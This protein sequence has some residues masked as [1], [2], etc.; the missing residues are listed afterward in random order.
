MSNFRQPALIWGILVAAVGF[1][2][3]PDYLTYSS[4]PVEL[5]EDANA[6]IRKDEVTVHIESYDQVTVERDRIV[7][8]RNESGMGDV[9]AHQFFDD[10]TSIR[11][12]NVIVYDSDGNEL[13]EI[14][15]RDFVEESAVSNGTL[16]SDSRVKFLRYIPRQ[17]PITFHFTSKVK[18]KSTAFLPSWTP[19]N[20]YYAST[21]SSHFKVINDADEVIKVKE[22]NLEDYNIEKLG[23]LSYSAT[24]IPAIQPQDYSPEFLTF[25]PQVKIALEHF[26]MEGVEGTNKDWQTFGKWMHDELLSDVGE[27]DQAVKE[28]V[29]ALTANAKTEREKAKLIYQFMQDRSRY[30]SVQVGIGGWKPIEADE[31][32]KMAYGDCKGLSNYTRALMETV[33]VKAEYAVIYGDR[34]IKNIDKDFSSTQGNHVVLYLPQLDNQEDVWLECT[35][36]TNPFGYIA[37]WTDDRDAL[38]VNKDGGRI[39]H[40]T[41]YPTEENT[42]TSDI[43]IQLNKDGSADAKIKIQTQGY[44]FQLREG[45]R[46]LDDNKADRVYQQQWGDINGLE[47]VSKEFQRDDERAI[48]REQLD[49]SIRKFASK[50]GNLFLFSPLIFNHNDVLPEAYDNRKY[51]LVIERGYIDEDTYEIKLD[52]GMAIDALP[53]PIHLETKFGRYESRFEKNESGNIQ[54][55]RYLKINNGQYAK[56]E[57]EEFRKF[58]AEIVKSDNRKAVIKTI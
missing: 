14:K 34:G 9:L 27:L 40:T 24:N 26:K 19:L 42:Q 17:Y 47:V 41:A 15:E 3:E 57:Y 8:V 53:E 56:E 46:E 30:I 50:A 4:I 44:Q 18:F 10:Q 33:G 38:V 12:L 31:V 13:T 58:R 6:I 7:T 39:V 20:Y 49:L 35:S 55:Y 16:Y 25:G 22:S 5:I 51:D 21:Q 48:F 1:G 28:E 43:S 36:K 23:N 32:H 2:Q 54:A 29:L 37:G 11:D 45:L 52:E